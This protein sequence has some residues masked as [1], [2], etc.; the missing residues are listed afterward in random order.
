MLPHEIDVEKS[1]ELLNRKM[2]HIVHDVNKQLR[3]VQH[4]QFMDNMFWGRKERALC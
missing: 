3:E 2:V 4:E 1:V